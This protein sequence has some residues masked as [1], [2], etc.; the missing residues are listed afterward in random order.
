MALTLKQKQY[1]NIVNKGGIITCCT[2]HNTI[3][4]KDRQ[5]FQT[6]NKPTSYEKASIDARV[7]NI[8][9]HPNKKPT[10]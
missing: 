10:R 1:E 7:I 6:L 9:A 3:M 5:I 8:D 2:R 4:I